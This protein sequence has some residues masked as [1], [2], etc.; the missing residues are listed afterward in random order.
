[1][2]RGHFDHRSVPSAEQEA[3]AHLAL[4]YNGR[5]RRTAR[6]RQGNWL[7]MGRVEPAGEV[8]VPCRGAGAGVERC[9]PEVIWRYSK[10]VRT[11][12]TILLL[13]GRQ[14]PMPTVLRVGRYRFFF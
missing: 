13:Q 3:H 12:H 10:F 8:V 1:M 6:L 5:V 2:G 11:I 4:L 7:P 14:I 9:A